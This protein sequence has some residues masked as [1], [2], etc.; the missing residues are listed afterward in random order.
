[1]QNRLQSKVVWAAIIAQVL[2]ILLALGVID[3]GMSETINAVVVSV[4]Q[5]LVALGVL[6]NPVNPTA[7]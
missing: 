2:A 1:M 6:N 5:L 3:T 7:F 4:L